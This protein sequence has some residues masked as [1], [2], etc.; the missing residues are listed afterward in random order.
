MNG[1]DRIKQDGLL[2]STFFISENKNDFYVSEGR[3]AL[4]A[5][6][7]DL[8]KEFQRICEEHSLNYFAICGTLLGAVRH[9]GFIPWDDDLDVAMPRADYEKLKNLRSEFKYPYC[10]VW[11]SVEPEN[12]YSF[13][14]L[15]NSETTG[16]SKRFQHLRINHGLFI[17]IFPL[18]EVDEKKYLED[19]ST[20]KDLIIKNSNNMTLLQSE[21]VDSDFIRNE[22]LATYNEIEGLA[23]EDKG[24]GNDKVALR[25]ISFYAPDHLIWDK[26]DFS[27]AVE[28]PF[29]EVN[30]RIP[31]G[32]K[33]IL[34]TN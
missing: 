3:K 11:P 10:L 34:E 2:S 28:V 27:K 23:K 19:Q 13:M 30:I 8:L 18:D 20:I 5:V 21:D 29:E 12:G 4:W 15:R 14:K 16:M 33:N 17:D 7:L 31:V 9:H 32:W 25:T 24:N 22:I 26:E 6:L 1:L